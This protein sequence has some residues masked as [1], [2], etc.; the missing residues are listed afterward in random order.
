M[1][2][3][4]EMLSYFVGFAEAAGH[5]FVADHQLCDLCPKLA[6]AKALLAE[7]THAVDVAEAVIAPAAAPA[8]EHKEED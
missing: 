1:D 8:P 2:A 3:L 7:M 5:K 4:H 6:Q